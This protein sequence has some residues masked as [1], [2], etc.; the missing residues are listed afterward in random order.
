MDGLLSVNSKDGGNS[1]NIIFAI[2]DIKLYATV[3][4]LSTKDNQKLSKFL[5]GRFEKPEHWN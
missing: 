4:T 1:N 3:V 2:K 5:S